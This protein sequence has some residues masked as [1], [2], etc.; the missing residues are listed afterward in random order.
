MRFT[1]IDINLPIKEHKKKEIGV[2]LMLLY[3]FGYWINI[4]SYIKKYLKNFH[5]MIGIRFLK[6][7]HFEMVNNACLNGYL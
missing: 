2:K 3:Y 6:V 5:K 1:I 4:V 7:F